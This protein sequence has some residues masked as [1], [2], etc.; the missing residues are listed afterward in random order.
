M[1]LLSA[2]VLFLLLI[3]TCAAAPTAPRTNGADPEVARRWYSVPEN[4][5]PSPGGYRAWP[6]SQDGSF[7]INYCFEDVRTHDKMGALFK[8]ALAKWAPALR[9]SALRFAPDP[10]C[11]QEP[12]L[13]S[14]SRLSEAT[15]HI[16]LG[17]RSSRITTSL[18]YR[19]SANRRHPNLPR[20]YVHYSSHPEYFSA[21]GPLIMAHELGRCLNEQFWRSSHVGSPLTV[22]GH[23]V[24]LLHEHQRPDA[25]KS[26]K[27]NCRALTFYDEAKRLVQSTP[28]RDE[29]EFTASMTIDDKMDLVFVLTLHSP[30]GKAFAD[31]HQ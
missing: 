8:L 12:C 26:V 21:E 31:N 22:T 13:C 27:F 2:P 11:Q 1:M 17:D 7:T 28:T 10:S 29:P 3:V 16:M 5:E 14:Q 19:T 20:H 23:T 24:R 30:P 6:R 18:G 25:S 4:H 9:L 15:L